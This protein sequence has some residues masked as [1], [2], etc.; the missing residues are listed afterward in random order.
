MKGACRMKFKGATRTIKDVIQQGSATLVIK[1][2][3]R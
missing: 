3:I 1:D 2:F